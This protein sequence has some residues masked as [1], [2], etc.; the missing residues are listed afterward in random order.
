[1]SIW[2]LDEIDGSSFFFDGT[3]DMSTLF[4]DMQIIKVYILLIEV[5]EMGIEK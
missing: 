1:M 5:I 2:A 3:I 4:F